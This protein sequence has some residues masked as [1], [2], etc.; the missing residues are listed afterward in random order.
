MNLTLMISR[1]I[2][3]VKS[4][5]RR[6]YVNIFVVRFRHLISTANLRIGHAASNED[7]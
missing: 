4:S 3:T 6:T 1:P 7:H 2:N 5:E